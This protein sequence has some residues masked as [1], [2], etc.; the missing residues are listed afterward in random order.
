MRR[1]PGQRS[2]KTVKAAVP[3]RSIKIAPA[4]PQISIA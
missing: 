2:R 1:I 4:M 3:A